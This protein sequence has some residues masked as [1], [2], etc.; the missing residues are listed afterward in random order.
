METQ[1]RARGIPAP[2]IAIAL[3]T[4]LCLRAFVL[5]DMQWRVGST[6]SLGFTEA[7]YESRYDSC[8][9]RDRPRV[10]AGFRRVLQTPLPA[11]AGYQLAA[12]IC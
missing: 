8:N 5:S 9:Q 1:A 4:V 6:R 3:T 2:L 12:R 11:V 7:Q 10:V